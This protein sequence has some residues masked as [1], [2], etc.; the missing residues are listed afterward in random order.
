MSLSVLPPQ[1]QYQGEN[2]RARPGRLLHQ[3]YQPWQVQVRGVVGHLFHAGQVAQPRVQRPSLGSGPRRMGCRRL[4]RAVGGRMS[5]PSSRISRPGPDRARAWRLRWRSPQLRRFGVLLVALSG[6]CRLRGVLRRRVH[7]DLGRRGN[8][9]GK[10]AHKLG[11]GRARGEGGQLRQARGPAQVG[12]LGLH[13][14]HV[15]TGAPVDLEARLALGLE[16]LGLHGVQD[17]QARARKKGQPAHGAKGNSCGSGWRAM[18]ATP[19]RISLPVLMRPSGGR[20]G[21]TA[22]GAR[23]RLGQALRRARCAPAG[24]PAPGKHLHGCGWP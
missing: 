19:R 17:E 22:V 5:C 11:H 13:L 9:F 7:G 23:P 1:A 15:G 18:S 14:G 20:M 21:E 12:P 3:G 24:P 8:G 2:R 4:P 6:A 10:P 16:H